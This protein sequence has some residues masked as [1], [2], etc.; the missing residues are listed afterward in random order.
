MSWTDLFKLFS[1]CCPG[2][3]PR[4]G[5]V[6]GYPGV[7]P[8][9]YIPD[10][11]DEDVLGHLAMRFR[12]LNSRVRNMQNEIGIIKQDYAITVDRLIKSGKWEE[13]PPPEDQLPHEHMPET[14]WQYW[15]KLDK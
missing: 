2:H 11:K 6:E 13:M 8:P 1:Y 12:D 14:F 15:W 10:I 3:K 9:D 4:Y 5:N 7:M